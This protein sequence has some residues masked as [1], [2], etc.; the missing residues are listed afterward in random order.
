MLTSLRARIGDY[1]L[2]NP[3]G[4]IAYNIRSILS[5]S[6]IHRSKGKQNICIFSSRRCGTTLLMQMINSQPGIKFIYEPLAR[7]RYNP[8]KKLIPATH[9]DQFVYLDADQQVQL[10]NYFNNVIFKDKLRGYSQW[11]YFSDSYSFI[12]DRFVIKIL[13]ALPIIDWFEKNFDVKIIYLIRHPIPVSLS[14]LNMGWENI[15]EAFICNPNFTK[16]YLNE[17][18]TRLSHHILK[19]GTKLQKL[20]LEWCLYHL[21][22]LSIFKRRNWLTITYE[23]LLLNPMKMVDLMCNYLD[24]P[25]RERMLETIL[26][27]S[28]TTSRQSKMD[29]LEKGPS[30]M[31]NRWKN[32]IDEK[33]ESEVMTIL[34]EFEINAYKKGSTIPSNR[35]L[36]F[37]SIGENEFKP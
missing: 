6:N 36:H 14:I 16:S 33:I 19:T 8:Y 12:S 26:K 23:E 3:N 10:R 13:D 24:L 31:I 4:V 17:R 9:L 34:E 37:G 35:L 1:F 7:Y 11:N 30:Y 22:P 32:K 27:P 18:T 15:S 28:R 21:Y 20:V 5:R 25:D 29:I 2:M